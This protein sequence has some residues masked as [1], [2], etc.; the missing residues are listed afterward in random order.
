MKLS[1]LQYFQ[2]VCKYNNLTRAAGELHISQP[3]LTHVIHELEREF[4][5]TLF[6]RQNKGLVLTEEGRQFLNESALLLEQAEAFSC[7]MKALGQANQVIQFGLAAASATL[8]FPSMMQEFHRQYPQVKVNIVENGSVAN[9]QHI[10]DGELDL[11][12]L[13]YGSSMSA[14]FGTHKIADAEIRLYIAGSH[15]LAGRQSVSVGELGQVPLVLPSED[16]FLT[17]NTRKICAQHKTKPN[18]ILTT[19]QIS[20]IKQLVENHTAGTIL[21]DG[22]LPDSALYRAVP[23]REFQAARIYLVWNQYNPV[24]AA[25]H[26]FIQTAKRL[27]PQPAADPYCRDGAAENQI[28]NP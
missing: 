5:L 25:V 20:V 26:H 18:I 11:A 4:G 27:Y 15:P 22:T 28:R 7:R 3:G 19:S 23:V 14:A 13:S 21:F 17:T 12:L 10:L 6:L 24:S 16:S 1:Q 2:T 8:Y 9:Y